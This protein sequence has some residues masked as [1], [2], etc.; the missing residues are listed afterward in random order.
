VF[1]AFGR[2]LVDELGTKTDSRAC[3]VVGIEVDVVG[4]GMF[5]LVVVRPNCDRFA[6]ER[7][8]GDPAR[9]ASRT[10]MSDGGQ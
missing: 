9:L 2:N 3:S 10:A 8:K 6:L 1:A 4:C 5:C 7:G